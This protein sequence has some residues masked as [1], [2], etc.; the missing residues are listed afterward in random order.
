MDGIV[1]NKNQVPNVGLC[2]LR[3]QVVSHNVLQ[4]NTINN[5]A[6]DSGNKLPAGLHRDVG[7]NRFLWGRL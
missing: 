4:T 1:N 6:G 2:L 5:R 7:N 3:S